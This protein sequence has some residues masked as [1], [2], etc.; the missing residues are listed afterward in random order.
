LIFFVAFF[1]LN[2]FKK[3]KDGEMWKDATSQVF[4]ILSACSGGLISSK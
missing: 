2:K 3:I 4:F 1:K